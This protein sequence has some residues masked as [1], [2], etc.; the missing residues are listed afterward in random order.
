MIMIPSL[1]M[2]LLSSYTIIVKMEDN[3]TRGIFR[4]GRGRAPRRQLTDDTPSEDIE[5]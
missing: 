3:L 4:R 2:L 5:E 1:V